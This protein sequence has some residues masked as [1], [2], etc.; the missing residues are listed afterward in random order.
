MVK[1]RHRI[2]VIQSRSAASYPYRVPGRQ[3]AVT[4]MPAIDWRMNHQDQVT[5]AH[6]DRATCT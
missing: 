1:G 6:L 4:E 5:A 2:L 3:D